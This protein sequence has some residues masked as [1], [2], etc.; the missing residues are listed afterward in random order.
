MLGAGI[1]GLASAIAFHG[2]GHEV[3][4]VER[5]PDPPPPFP[6]QSFLD[7]QRPGV[8]Q[9]RLVHGFLPLARRRLRESAPDLVA[10]LFEAGAHDID[11]LAPLG[12]RI[13]RPG[14]E[15]LFALRSRRTVFEWVMRRAA[16]ERVTVVAGE[17][18]SGLLGPE[19]PGPVPRVT[20]VALAS[21]RRLVADLVVDASGR[22]SRLPDWLSQLGATGV[23]EVSSPCG[24]VYYTRFYERP[25]AGFPL[26]ATADLGYLRATATG[27]DGSTFSLTFFARAE[28]PGL[29]RLRTESGF[30]A[31]AA[32]IPALASWRDGASPIGPVASMGGL[33]NRLRRFVTGGVPAA[34]GVI[35][36]G[37]SLGHSNPTLGRGMS[38]ALD[39]AFRAARLPWTPGDLMDCGAAYHSEVDPILEASHSDAVQ[40]DGLAARIHAGDRAASREPRAVLARATPLAAKHDPDLFRA[41]VRLNGL[42]DPPGSL[43][44]EP[45]ISRARAVLAA[46]ADTPPPGPDLASMLALLEEAT[47]AAP[48]GLR[49]TS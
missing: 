10:R 45:W 5:D 6:G 33:H 9:R 28:E 38:L 2:A 26:A 30:E 12:D 37:D 23:D 42:L 14:D 22:Q 24:L 21:G 19:T 44:S 3:T 18:V 49:T 7:W 17:P 32:S 8:P 16:G 4:L 34:A 13:P 20:G 25:E 47:P 31:A 43:A 15:E 39:Q 48:P 36:V 27:A 35:A 46:E 40:I 41:L 1:A 11:L 29:R